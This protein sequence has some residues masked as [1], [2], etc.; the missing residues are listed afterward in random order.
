MKP[1]V[2]V[3]KIIVWCLP[4]FFGIATET[5]AKTREYDPG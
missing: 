5:V 1:A 4:V 3:V 2:L